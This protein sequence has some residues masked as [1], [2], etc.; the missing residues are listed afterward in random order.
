MKDGEETGL[1]QRAEM[2]TNMFAD[3][4]DTT[5]A[6]AALGPHAVRRSL[7]K[8]FTGAA[9]LQPAK[10]TTHPSRRSRQGKEREGAQGSTISSAPAR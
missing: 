9:S 7:L 5:E 1:E 8:P 3:P 4:P 10:P 6:D 2:P